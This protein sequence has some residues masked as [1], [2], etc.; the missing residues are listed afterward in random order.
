[1]VRLSVYI[2]SVVFLFLSMTSNLAAA[3]DVEWDIDCP[4]CYGTSMFATFTTAFYP[5]GVIFPWP[6][7]SCVYSGMGSGGN[8]RVIITLPAGTTPDTYWVDPPYPGDWYEFLFDGETGAEINDNVVTLHL[9]DGKRG[10]LS[11]VDG[12][13][14]HKYSSPAINLP[15]ADCDGDGMPDDW[16]VSNDLNTNINDASEDPDDDG[17]T[18]FEEYKFNTDPQK[19][20]SDGDSMPDGWEISNALNP[21]VDDA[22]EDPDGDGYTNI[23]EYQ[24]GTNPNVATK[25]AMPW[26]PLMLLGE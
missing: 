14:V 21:L 5:P 12:T 23:K 8:M 10:D 15:C 22:S 7:F 26:I 25:T 3:G 6:F 2:S 16:E 18:N 9:V 11:P 4:G 17:L 19:A 1:M 24:R 13:I 20:D